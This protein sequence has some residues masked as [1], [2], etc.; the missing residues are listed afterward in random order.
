MCYII[1]QTRHYPLK[2]TSPGVVNEILHIN[3][4]RGFRTL[5]F[6]GHHYSLDCF[7]HSI[8]YVLQT[9][10]QYPSEAWEA[11]VRLLSAPQIGTTEEKGR[12]FQKNSER[13]LPAKSALELQFLMCTGVENKGSMSKNPSLG[14]NFHTLWVFHRVTITHA[15][16]CVSVNIHKHDII[17]PDSFSTLHTQFTKWHQFHKPSLLL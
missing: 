10:L 7:Q 5:G 9:S 6:S 8:N 17:K 2:P 11:S 12:V 14:R 4:I 1:I 13:G 3:V 15:C 16:P